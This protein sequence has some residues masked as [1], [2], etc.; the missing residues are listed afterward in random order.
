MPNVSSSS[1]TTKVSL[2]NGDSLSVG[3][4]LKEIADMDALR[5]ALNMCREAMATALPWNRSISAI[6]GFLNTNY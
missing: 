5:A 4:N 3:V 2:K 6:V 1:L